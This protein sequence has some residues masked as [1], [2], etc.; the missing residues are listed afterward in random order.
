[1]LQREQFDYLVTLPRPSAP[2]AMPDGA[3]I[4]MLLHGWVELIDDEI[5]LTRT[6]RVVLATYAGQQIQPG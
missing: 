3:M 4:D 1:M 6:G 2:D 5:R